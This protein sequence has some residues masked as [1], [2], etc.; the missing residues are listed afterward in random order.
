MD[1]FG[2]S[3][4]DYKHINRLKDMGAYETRQQALAAQRGS[5]PS[6][7][8]FQALGAGVP[9]QY[10]RAEPNAQALGFITDN[11]LAIQAQVDEILY[12]KHRLPDLIHQNTNIPEGAK[13]YGVR[14]VD[15]TGRGEY[16]TGD[17]TDA[18]NATVSQKMTPIN[19]DYAGIDANWTVEDIRE[20]AFTGIPLDTESVDAAVQGAMRHMEEVGLKGDDNKGYLGL[21]N[22]PVTG[23]GQV[24]RSHAA[25]TFDGGTT[26]A[27]R[28]LI[29]DEISKLIEDTDEVFG[30]SIDTNLCV[31]LPVRQ[32]NRLGTRFVGDDQERTILKSLLED[33][34]WL[35]RTGNTIMFKSVQELKDAGRNAGVTQDV[36]RMI[37]ACN[38]KRV[39]EMGVSIAPRVL[40]ILDKGRTMCAQVEY[41]FSRLFVKR[42]LTIHYVDGI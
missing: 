23:T 36:D 30:D 37:V 9:A 27:I 38:D 22:L 40:R 31:Y 2:R 18:P 25:S 42:P 11:L 32:Y 19:L 1:I 26:E 21:V 20:A 13:T 4:S 16:I 10:H 39:F 29:N 28:N 8:N 7:H 35:H 12:T 14:T 5:V 3:E 34:P 33:N 17:G 24:T 15:H 41:K 6:P